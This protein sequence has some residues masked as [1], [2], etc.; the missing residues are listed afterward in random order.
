MLVRVL[1]V[2]GGRLLSGG[3]KR[4]GCATV[5]VKHVTPRAWH[6]VG[7]WWAH[8]GTCSTK[9]PAWV[10]WARDGAALANCCRLLAR[11]ADL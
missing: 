11:H 6:T 1:A 8:G 2:C 10:A 3:R 4:R 9:P 5:K 7:T